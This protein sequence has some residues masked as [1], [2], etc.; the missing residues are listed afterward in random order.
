MKIKDFFVVWKTFYCL[1]SS[2]SQFK[3]LSFNVGRNYIHMLSSLLLVFAECT[4]TRNFHRER[5]KT[6]EEEYIMCRNCVG[7][8]SCHRNS[9]FKMK[10]VTGFNAGNLAMSKECESH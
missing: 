6:K 3:R 7:R 9:L 10:F 1:C 5:G 8:T 4:S 2:F